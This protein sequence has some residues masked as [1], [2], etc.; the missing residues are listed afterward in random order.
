MEPK[1][2]YYTLPNGTIVPNGAPHPHIPEAEPPQTASLHLLSIQALK[3]RVARLRARP[4]SNL[5]ETELKELEQLMEAQIQAH[6][7]LVSALMR[8]IRILQNAL[9]TSKTLE[10]ESLDRDLTAAIAIARESIED[11]K[12]IG[13]LYHGYH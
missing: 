13:G 11:T 1:S 6:E 7:R 3:E 4:E 9:L 5:P 2:G 12:S 10:A 8:Q